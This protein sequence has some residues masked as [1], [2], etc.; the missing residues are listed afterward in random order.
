VKQ[1]V[2]FSVHEVAGQDL[3][4]LN[5]AVSSGYLTAQ[6]ISG[7]LTAADFRAAAM[8]VPC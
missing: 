3:K 2:E 6:P 4:W 5:G 7:D 1:P 8:E